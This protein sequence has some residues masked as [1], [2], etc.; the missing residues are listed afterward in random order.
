MRKHPPQPNS[1]DGSFQTDDNPEPTPQHPNTTPEQN[2]P[3]TETTPPCKEN[4][5]NKT[6]KQIVAEVVLTTALVTAVLCALYHLG[7]VIPW[8]NK[9]LGGL[10]AVLFVYAAAFRIWRA[11]AEL[12]DYGVSWRPA[13]ANVAWGLGST[14]IVLSLFTAVYLLYYSA[15]CTEDMMLLGPLGRDCRRFV[16]SWSQMRWTWPRGFWEVA[17]AEV[18]V[19]AIPE[20]VF[21]RGYVQTRLNEVWKQRIRLFGVEMGWALVAQA[22]LFGLGHFL[23]DFNPLRLAVAI[24]ALAFGFLRAASGSVA[25]PALF[26]AACNIFVSAIDYNFFPPLR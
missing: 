26:H 25:A 10:A 19:V 14:L 6:N 22:V 21:F 11:D 18:L 15:V 24:P 5:T 7:F 2:K 16:G 1:T 13:G 4:K 17:L 9:N 20:E 8:L 12:A 3:S 23:V